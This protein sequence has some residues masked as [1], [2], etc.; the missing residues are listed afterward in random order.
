MKDLEK[1]SKVSD[2]CTLTIL[3]LRESYNNWKSV[4]WVVRIL[5]EAQG[6]ILLTTGTAFCV[7]SDGLILTSAHLFPKTSYV[8]DVRRLDEAN[9]RRANVVFEKPKWDVILLQVLDVNGCQYATLT[10]DGSLSVGQSLLHIGNPYQFV[11]SFLMG[12]VAFECIDHVEVPIFGATCKT[13]VSTALST[14]PGH[15]IMGHVWNKDIFRHSSF[16][17]YAKNLHPLVP[18]IQM[19]S[20][21]CGEGCS[22]GPR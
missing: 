10:N 18:I 22:G 7:S 3:E 19:Y 20:L 5:H 12:K 2:D 16:G 17:T 8:L 21:I 6:D 13:Y 1:V 4:V 9:F 15:R 11:G 14:T